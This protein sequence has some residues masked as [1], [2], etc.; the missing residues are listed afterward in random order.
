MMSLPVWILKPL[1]T[2]FVIQS[3]RIVFM[4]YGFNVLRRAV[5]DE[6]YKHVQWAIPLTFIVTLILELLLYVSGVHFGMDM[7]FVKATVSKVLE[8]LLSLISLVVSQMM[9]DKFHADI[10][11]GERL[12]AHLVVQNCLSFTVGWVAMETMVQLAVMLEKLRDVSSDG[13]WTMMLFGTI[14]HNVIWTYDENIRCREL[15]RVAVTTHVHAPVIMFMAW[16]LPSVPEGVT[17]HM[18][19]LGNILTAQIVS[20]VK[21]YFTVNPETYSEAMERRNG[22]LPSR[23]ELVQ[24]HSLKG[25]DCRIVLGRQADPGLPPPPSQ[26]GTARGKAAYRRGAGGPRTCT[27]PAAARSASSLRQLGR[28]KAFPHT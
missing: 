13:L 26:S 3:W 23:L 10:P 21:I 15:C 14:S 16:T 12:F 4:V 19:H 2:S 27:A 20:P 28:R 18:A 17:L 1:I 8:L 24:K 6:K 9:T 25:R 11:V 5:S 22:R 7:W